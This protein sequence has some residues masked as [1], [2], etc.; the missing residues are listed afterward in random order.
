MKNYQN[1]FF[2]FYLLL[3]TFYLNAQPPQG[4]SGTS[5]AIG[6]ISGKIVDAAKSTPLE[7]SSVT[8]KN[9]KDSSIILGSLVDEKGFFEITKI[10]LGAYELTVSYVGYK[11]FVKKP[12]MVIPPD[13]TDVN[14]GTLK[15]EEDT[16]ILEE[17]QI[18]AEK[19]FMQVNAEK[20][21]F[22]MDKNT[23]STG[24]SAVDALKQVSVVEVDQDG[25][26]S[27]RGSGNLR[28]FING[29]PSGITAA[30]TKAVLDAIPSSQIESIEVIN[31]PSAKYDAEGE[32]GIINIVLKKNTKS[33][34]N[35]NVTVGYGTKYDANTGVTINYRKNNISLSTSYNFRFTESYYK[36]SSQRYNFFPGQ[37]PFYLN[38]NDR[39][40][41]NNFANT[42][43]SNVDWNI[44][45]KN[46]LSF[47]VLLS[48]S[49]G[50][51][52]GKV[53]TDFLDSL[54]DYINAY[55]RYNETK[56]LNWNAELNTSYRRTFKDN[57]NDLVIA[58]NYAYSNRN[59]TPVYTQKTIDIN[60]S[61][62]ANTDLLQRNTNDNITHSG[63]VQADYTQPFKKSKSKL[64]IGYK[65]SIRDIE[66][67]LY[68]D[69]LIRSTQQYV[70]DSSVSNKYRFNE[71][72]HAGYVI[73]GGAVKKVFT[74][75]AGIRLENTNIDIKQQVGNQ[76]YKQKYFDY[77]PSASMS[78]NLPKSHSLSLSYSK[79]INRPGAEQLNPFGN[80]S[81]PF[82]ILTGNPRM[83]PAYTHALE[84]THVK[85]IELKP[86]KKDSTFQR[87]IFFSTTVYYRY[88]YNVFTR[89]RT[90]D[91][92]GRSIVYFDNLNVG[93]NIGAEFTGRVN[94]FRWW[95]FVLSANLYHN[96]VKGNVPNGEVDATTN[97][98]QYNLRLMNTFNINPK[99]SIQL[100]VMYRSKI[101]FLQGEITPM[102]FA[103]LGF[104]Y[105]F[106]KNNKA[107]I[108]INVSDVFHTQYF[109]VSTGGSTFSGNVKRYWE[110]TVGNI[111]F[112]YR[113]GKSENK[114][115]FSKQKKSNF[116][117]SGSGIDGGGG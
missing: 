26:L 30:N 82:N 5:P 11:D 12:V 112:T 67:A 10:P 90:V 34:L 74:Y 113:F 52:K 31:N 92:I 39:G 93:Q 19:S 22:N 28:V 61:E 94:V 101:K 13:K 76:E 6:R 95:N 97:S 63:F 20:K 40:T 47:S 44:K 68:G 115:Q 45:E 105:D 35:G 86:S 38:T 80:Y 107:S 117:D 99:A 56:N 41:F 55:N 91:S 85:N 51:T 108:A 4:F 88:A 102:V 71:M 111:V 57:S 49:N 116:E 104:K 27:M 21:V 96:K 114:G 2:S 43:N 29:K 106:L 81:D 48:E 98:F 70:Y 109:G 60:N 36:G 100:M 15:V 83:K 75:K 64:E 1:Y 17:V 54:I 9:L 103:N 62:S 3:T 84:L 37:T 23:L 53:H 79:R 78:F 25:N 50:V 18:T 110:S 59:S 24:G 42:L 33:G 77:F 73:F 72:I 8:I 89:Y 14:L 87:S 66:S 58:G 7:Y 69:S 46:S 32:V 16:K 65:F